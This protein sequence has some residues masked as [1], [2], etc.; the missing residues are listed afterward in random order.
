MPVRFL[1][2]L[3]AV[4]AHG[5]TTTAIDNEWVRVLVAHQQP[6]VKT[7]L[8]EHKFNRVMVYVSS[9][10]EAFTYPD[11]PPSTMNF[12]AGEAQ[13]SPVSGMHTAEITSPDPVTIVE[14]ELKGAKRPPPTL[15]LGATD[16]KYYKVEFEND[17]VRVLRVRIGPHQSTPEFK[18]PLNRVVVYLTGEVV[19]DDPAIRKVE[20]PGGHPFEGVLVELKW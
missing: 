3:L 17:Q 10:R 2:F 14:I 12:K 20:N 18:D 15:P 16:P 5:Q 11:K 4:L 9:G 1:P 8:H 6:H 13:W 19:W 7:P